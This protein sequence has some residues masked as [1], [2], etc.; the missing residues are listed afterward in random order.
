M[1]LLSIQHL[2]ESLGCEVVGTTHEAA[3]AVDLVK[4]LR[5][6]LV[7]MD[8]GLPDSDALAATRTIT[9][10]LDTR[11]VVITA[12][13]ERQAR[14][15]ARRAGASRFLTKPLQETELAQAISELTRDRSEN[16]A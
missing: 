7:F 11:V 14:A 15:A 2:L 6:D 1:V 10:H 16:A 4:S 9:S 8:L 5:P 13:N 12:Y 3:S